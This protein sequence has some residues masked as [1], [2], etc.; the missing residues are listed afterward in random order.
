MAIIHGFQLKKEQDIKEIATRARFFRHARTGAEL[1]SL[2]NDDEN[3]VFGITFRTP[4]LDSTG[5][6]HILEHSVLCGSRKY[7]VKEPFVELLKGSLHTFLNAFTYPDRTCYPVASQNLRDFYNLIDVYLDAVFH[8]LLTPFIF[9]QEGWHFELEDVHNPL[10]YKG[11]VFNEM[12]GAYSSPDSVLG[13]YVLQSL[14]PDNPYCFDAGGDPKQIPDLAFEQFEAFRQTYYHPS[15]ARIYFY[16]DDDPDERLRITD[17]YLKDFDPAHIDSTIR[18]Q[19]HFDRPRRV[20][21][22]FRA[23]KLDGAKAKGMITVNWLLPENTDAQ[24]NFSHRILEYIL[25]GMPASPLRKALIDS[26]LGEDLAGGGLGNELRQGYFST[27]LK[28]INPEDADRIEAL[29]METLTRLA[30]E[31]INP[32]T[33]EAA[34]NTIEFRLRENHS[35]HFPQG[36][37]L[38]LRSLSTWIYDG[39]PLALLAFEA[40]LEKVKSSVES[41]PRFFDDLITRLFIDNHHRTTLILNPDPGLQEKDEAAEKD[42]LAEIRSAMNE[43]ELDEIIQGTKELKRLQQTPDLPEALATIPVLRLSDLDKKNRI[44]PLTCLDRRETPILFHDLSTSGIV[45]LDLGFNLRTIPDRLLPY[46]SIF[47]R[48][49]VEMGTEKEDFVTLTQRISRNTGG[50][51]PAIFASSVSESERSTAWLFLRG[52]AMSERAGELTRILRDVLLDLSLD[53]R[54]RLRQ[55]VMEEKA[56]AEQEIIPKGHQAIN[57]RLKAHFSEAHW[58]VEQIMGISYL[59]FLR[60]LAVAI[61]ENWPDVLACLEEIRSI[62]VNRKG[63]IANVTMEGTGWS[64]FEPR[65][66]ALIDALPGDSVVE[67]DWS[68]KRPASFEGMTIPSEVNYVGKGADIYNMGYSFHGSAMVICRYLRSSWLW[69]NVRVQ[70]GAYGAFCFFDRLSGGFSLVSYRDPNIAKTLETFDLAARFLRDA[71]LGEKELTKGIIGAIGEIDTHMLPDAKG[72]TSMLRYL[73]NDTEERRQRMREEVLG[74]KAADFRAF[75]QVLEEVK[76]KGLVKV[77]GSKAAIEAVAADRP[78]WLKVFKVL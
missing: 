45:H 76:N 47:G 39:D 37:V 58:A 4:P 5:T 56:R 33:K 34:L 65:L 43:T 57:L 18:L 70:G 7:H 8:P 11:V 66:N 6:P 15:N 68:P 49:L 59:L 13:E 74:T 32:L 38:M 26:G 29:V 2:T 28:G 78:D 19:P 44:I 27:G 36:L 35:G 77:L 61:D 20:M 1:L 75:S 3:K 10:I 54:E 31:G 52:K 42:R 17:E 23:G 46:V 24:M 16:G 64:D 72:Y 55:I 50:I 30:R 63:V 9:Q 14:F 22:P 21:R 69:D 40:P 67:V 62:L 71:D 51:S 48:A 73:T 60:E 41:D 25:L 53:N 12:K